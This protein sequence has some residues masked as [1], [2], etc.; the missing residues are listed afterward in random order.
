MICNEDFETQYD[1]IYFDK[2]TAE[3]KTITGY[4]LLNSFI[5]C[6]NDYYLIEMGKIYCICL[7]KE[8]ELY[9]VW[10]RGK[11]A[12]GTELLPREVISEFRNK[13]LKEEISQKEL[14]LFISNPKKYIK[15][16][17]KKLQSN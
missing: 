8:N 11:Y 13:F 14:D 5:L 4:S 17:K 10:R 15:E 1:V 2:E 9:S 6:K 3:K 16:R 7:M 12:D